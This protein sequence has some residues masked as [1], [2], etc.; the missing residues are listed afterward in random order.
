[1]RKLILVPLFFLLISPAF[2]FGSAPGPT[3][4][5]KGVL[6]IENFEN[7]DPNKGPEWWSF[8]NLS[9]ALI[10]GKESKRAVELKGFTRNWY[11]G[12]IGKYIGKDAGKYNTFDLDIYGT[13]KETATIKIELYDDDNGNWQIEQDPKNNYAPTKDDRFVYE[14][15]IDW[16]GWKH[17]SI[18]ITD[19]ADN[20]P[21]IGDDIWNPDQA[22]GSGG[23]IQMQLIVNATKK[24][25]K[26]DLYIDNIEMREGV[27]IRQR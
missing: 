11:V 15:R 21:G 23:L 2:G 5:A 7:V 6:V 18:P 3:P 26:V 8:D 1:M 24:V 22:N 27:S 9:M 16:N 20:N 14:M 13:G 12:G 19:F 17:I 25:G 4:P 10:S